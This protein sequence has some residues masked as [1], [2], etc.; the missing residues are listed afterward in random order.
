VGVM[1]GIS[2][3]FM[4]NVLKKLYSRCKHM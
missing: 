4:K 3:S 2:R 1:G